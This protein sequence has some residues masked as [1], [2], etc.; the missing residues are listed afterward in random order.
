M[1]ENAAPENTAP[2]TYEPYNHD[3]AQHAREETLWAPLAPTERRKW[4]RGLVDFR[5]DRATPM[6]NRMLDSMMHRNGVISLESWVEPLLAFD[7]AGF[8]AKDWLEIMTSLHVLLARQADLVV[9]SPVVTMLDDHPLTSRVLI[10]PEAW[11]SWLPLRRS[12]TS[13]LSATHAVLRD[14]NPAPAQP[15]RSPLRP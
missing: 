3:R 13:A 11:L 5:P 14:A 10:A 6:T 15:Q 4:S 2:E 7:R 9:D 8:T 1:S 12:G